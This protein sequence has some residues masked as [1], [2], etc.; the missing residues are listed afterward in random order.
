MKSILLSLSLCAL[1]IAGC[2]N[3]GKD[4]DPQ[5]TC[6]SL[7]TRID[8]LENMIATLELNENNAPR[9]YSAAQHALNVDPATPADRDAAVQRWTQ[10]ISATPLFALPNNKG[11]YIGLGDL[12]KFLT[13][14]AHDGI[15]IQFGIDDYDDDNNPATAKKPRIVPFIST[16]QMNEAN[17]ASPVDLLGKSKGCPQECY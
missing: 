11:F 12:Y 14:N 15:V 1:I 3:G 17:H 6:D 7:K 9:I 13:R 8:S 2:K 16:A 4:V 5:A 10:T